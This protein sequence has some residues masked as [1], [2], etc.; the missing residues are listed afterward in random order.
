VN[1][2]GILKAL[3]VRKA[4]H[5]TINMTYLARAILFKLYIKINKY[6]EDN[7][8]HTASLFEH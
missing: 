6:L 2:S 8:Y 5:N 7:T 1:P 3:Q 4:I